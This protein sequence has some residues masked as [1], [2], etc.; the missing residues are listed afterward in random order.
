LGLTW[1]DVD[2]DAGQVSIRYQLDRHSERVPLKTKR[3]RRVIDT[4][5]AVLSLLRAHK[6]RTPYS[7]QN[8]L[9][10]ASARVVHSITATWPAEPSTGR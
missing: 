1:A 8:D 2:L 5:A 9:V 6:L 10:L 3:S 4:P 7:G